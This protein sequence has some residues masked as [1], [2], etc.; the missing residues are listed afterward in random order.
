MKKFIVLLAVTVA[1]AAIP[2]VS[3]ASVVVDD[4]SPGVSSLEDFG[5]VDRTFFSGAFDSGSGVT[6][7]PGFSSVSYRVTG[8][9]PGGSRRTF[10]DLGD[11][12][13]GFSFSS[14]STTPGSVFAV[15]LFGNNTLLDFRALNDGP[16]TLDSDI[17]NFRRLT[18]AVVGFGGTATLGG[19]F[20]A[21]PEPTSLI[22]VGIAC[23]VL[24]LRRRRLA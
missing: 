3:S 10:G 5:D 18:L 22:L 6:F 1:T 19:S 14:V 4:F 23:S 24:G 16:I 2:S 12:S 9:N 13:Q 21:V 17:S 7:T 15:A 20:S 8:R 11:F